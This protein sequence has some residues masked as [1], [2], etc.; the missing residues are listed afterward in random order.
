MSDEYK[1]LYASLT[2]LGA[3][4]KKAEAHINTL[5]AKNEVFIDITDEYRMLNP[6]I[7]RQ[8]PDDEVFCNPDDP[9]QFMLRMSHD[10]EGSTICFFYENREDGLNC[11]NDLS[12]SSSEEKIFFAKYIPELIRLADLKVLELAKRAEDYAGEIEQALMMAA[13]KPERKAK[14]R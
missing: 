1:K 8:H 7:D 3:A 6:W 2:V 9:T 12:D 11:L 14:K 4:I 5:P 10:D 13:K